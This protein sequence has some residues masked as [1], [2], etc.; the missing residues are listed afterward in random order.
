MFI[1]TLEQ[2]SNNQLIATGK[3]VVINA[4]AGSGKSSSL[5]YHAS[6]FPGKNFLVLCFNSANAKE[7]NEHPDKPSNIY[8]STIH[9]VAY[10]EIMSKDTNARLGQYLN[11]R[12]IDSR[13]LYNNGLLA[14]AKDNEEKQKYLHI[15]FKAILT[16]ITNYCRSDSKD[17]LEFAYSYCKD[18]F[19]NEFRKVV[20][21]GDENVEASLVLN[22]T[23]C[24]VLAT[25]TREHWLALIDLGNKLTITHDVYLKL[26]HLRQYS[27]TSFFDKSAKATVDIDVLCLDECQ[28]NNPVTIAILQNTTTKQ[29]IIVGDN[30]QQ[31]YQWRGS[32]NTM[33]AFDAYCQ[34]KLTTSFRFSQTIADIANNILGYA[35]AKLDIKGAYE[36][37]NVNTKAILCRTNVQV[38]TSILDACKAGL[39]VYTPL[40]LKDTF[41]RMYHIQAV[42]FGQQPKY[43]AYSL[44][45][46]VTKQDL[47]IASELSEDIALLQKLSLALIDTW[48]SLHI[49]I[50]QIKSCLVSSAQAVDVTISTIH[51]AKGLEWDEVTITDKLIRLKYDKFGHILDAEATIPA[52][53]ND[54][55][56]I[57]LLYVAVTRA[58]VKINFPSYLSPFIS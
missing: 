54:F 33:Q 34:G 52:W 49:A 6:M 36:G 47:V 31:L 8:Y 28:D 35:G 41:S 7:S 9:A 22:D 53:F 43:P 26:F 37:N 30:Y 18:N 2:Q 3:D 15:L 48:G 38:L 56:N 21:N 16:C 51:K 23:Q 39:K 11:Y 5:R 58:R 1:P 17:L 55:E 14:N 4:V 32:I 40:D 57:C 24:K 45:D 13:K 50:T 27:I 20:V 46:I 29:K 10:S 12:E 25:I 42:Y 19:T 44:K